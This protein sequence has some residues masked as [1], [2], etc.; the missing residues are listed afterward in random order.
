MLDE[1]RSV[2]RESSALG[3]LTAEGLGTA[4]LLA[5][6]VGS[7]Q[8]VERLGADPAVTLFIHAVVVGAGLAVLIAMFLPISG[9]HFNPVVT[10]AVL[11]GGGIGRGTAARYLA[12]QSIGAVLGVLVANL[13]FGSDVLGMSGTV[14]DGIGRFSGEIFATF[15]LVLV[16]LVLVAHGRLSA[17]PISVG[18]W[19]ATVIVATVST[20]FANP[21]VT[22][23][24]MFTDSYTGIAP[25]SVPAFVA[26]QALG[27]ILAVAAVWLLRPDPSGVAR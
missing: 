1:R 14:R 9:A 15:G 18:A 5:V 12:V 17:I 27:A 11:V 25:A 2:D 26:A 6:I 4:M 16:I 21:A 24:R 8:A 23:A 19:V 22:V 7:G 20:G 3:A 13:M 10:L